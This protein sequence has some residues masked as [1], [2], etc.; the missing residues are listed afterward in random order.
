MHLYSLTKFKHT[1]H[2]GYRKLRITKKRTHKLKFVSLVSVPWTL[3][4]VLDKKLNGVFLCNSLGDTLYVSSIFITNPFKL[5]FLLNVYNKFKGFHSCTSNLFFQKYNSI[6]LHLFFNETSSFFGHSYKSKIRFVRKD[7]NFFQLILPSG[8][9]KQL[10]LSLSLFFLQKN[11]FRLKK[12]R[13]AVRG[14]AKNC[15]D[16]PNGGN[17]NTRSPF[18]TPWGRV[19]K[20]NR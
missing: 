15:V 14:I 11:S 3:W 16:H 9:K 18:K 17:S 5:A 19:A 12:K 2:R 7:S 13:P 6:I 1:N 8:F 20:N 4:F 10:P